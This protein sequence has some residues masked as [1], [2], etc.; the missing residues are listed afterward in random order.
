[1]PNLRTLLTL[2]AL[3]LLPL[4][5]LAQDRATLVADRVS[6][7]SASVLLAE[8]HVEVYF[9][10][11]RL[12]ASAILY[13]RAADRLTITGPIRI[14]DGK[15]SVFTA[16]QAELSA[17]LTE[18]LLTSARLVLQQQ[19]Q[20]TAAELIR[21]EGGN[22][23]AMRRVAA[24]SCTICA[25]NPTPL[26]EI[27]A[28]EVVHDA[29]ARQ[30]YFRDA[31]LRFYG[32]PVLYLPMLR[33]PDPS[34]KRATGFLI[35]TLRST[36]AL[37]TGVKLPFFVALGDSRDLTLTPYLTAQGDRTVELRYRQA[38]GTGS[39]EV[40]GAVS[41]DDLG[42]RPTRGYIRAEGQ[43]DLGRDYKLTFAGALVSDR[44]YLSDYGI[45]D[46]DRLINTLGLTRVRRDLAFAAELIGFRSFR[47]GDDNATLPTTV[48]NLSY[49]RR[50]AP[51]LLGGMAA[52]RLQGHGDYRSAT[53][54][55]DSDGDGVADGRD[56]GRISLSFDWRRTWTT[57]GGLVLSALSTGAVDS[58]SITQDDVFG[59]TPQRFSG[60]VG[61][62]LRWP[63]VKSGANGVTQTIEPVVQAV[64]SSRP[65]TDIPNGDSTLV[66][67]DE[68]NLLA[69]DRY[70]GADAVEG[71]ARLNLGLTWARTDPD[72]WSVAGTVGRVIRAEDLGQFSNASGL[73]G[74]RSDWLL[75]WS[76]STKGGLALT[77]R[78]V[79]DD[80]LALTK[81]ALRFD[82]ATD[83][84][85]LSGGYEYLLAD[86][87][88]DRP[89]TAS[90]IVL[91]A[92]RNLTPNW[93]ANLS[94]RYDLR[95]QRFATAGLELDF[96]NECIDVTL[97]L[98]RRY[99]SSTSVRPST[100]FGL[101]VE[102]LGFGGGS[103]GGPS[104]T[105]R[106]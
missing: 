3:C 47:D 104:R 67:F 66:E 28:S 74:L 24:S 22:L 63:L 17:D 100:D 38:F 20:L 42:P 70:P 69:L 26:W 18:G 12:T 92:G 83:A 48:V 37:G 39:V 43:F 44:S 99:T 45:T 21:S 58:Y 15:G 64:V 81:G 11:Q 93:R 82:L 19:L 5:A 62:E 105:C 73:N 94:S 49:E 79:L 59:G 102:L 36:T 34:L 103:D 53:L 25:G 84:V 32:L 52:V 65:V 16:E 51:P 89:D 61:V 41:Q 55:A 86:A 4:T 76:L 85:D 78:V 2:L 72:G 96:S 68:G 27:R 101:S 95:A 80:R 71:G 7:L 6:V 88:E 87:D 23:T 90:E 91:N 98:S 56:L 33:V 13:D 30:I 46:E 31:T 29:R 9:R 54:G 75:A 106:R 60:A 40:N 14:D 97:S 8:G 10:G 1:M 57:T 77:N 35:P 50:F